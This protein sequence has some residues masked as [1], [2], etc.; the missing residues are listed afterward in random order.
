MPPRLPCAEAGFAEP[1]LG[2]QA[3]TCCSQ[4]DKQTAIT[5]LEAQRWGIS[6]L[7]DLY[8][9]PRLLLVHLVRQ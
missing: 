5:V 1:L 6:A 8:F 4:R 9:L 3:A 7:T 2:A